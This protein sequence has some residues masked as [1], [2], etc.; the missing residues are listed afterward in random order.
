MW[1]ARCVSI[2]A[3]AHFAVVPYCDA[4]EPVTVSVVAGLTGLVSSA[5]WFGKDFLL[6]NTY[7]KFTECCRKPYIKADV[8]GKWQIFNVVVLP[9]C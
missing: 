7:C 9:T 6:D 5:G 1:L 2:L 3:F 8:A 4:V